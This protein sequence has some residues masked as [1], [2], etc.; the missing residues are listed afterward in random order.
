MSVQIEVYLWQLAPG[1]L[2]RPVA[3]HHDALV[4]HGRLHHHKVFQQLILVGGVQ[5]SL[6]D[7]L[8]EA[9]RS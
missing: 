1:E 8:V 5:P 4:L 7:L 3:L 2:C 9:R 6:A